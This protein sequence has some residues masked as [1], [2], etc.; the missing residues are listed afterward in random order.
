[1]HRPDARM[2]GIRLWLCGLA[3][4]L[5]LVAWALDLHGWM[6]S[7]PSDDIS[8]TLRVLRTGLCA[9]LPWIWLPHADAVDRRRLGLGLGLCALADGA[10][11]GLA[12]F[13]PGVLAFLVAQ[14]VLLRRAADGLRSAIA[15]RR[16]TAL[17]TLG[18]AGLIWLGLLALLGPPLAVRGFLPVV[19][20]YGLVLLATVAAAALGHRIGRHPG[21]TGRRMVW[22]MLCFALCDVLVGVGA[23]LPSEPLARLARLHTGWFYTPALLLLASSVR[24]SAD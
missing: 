21:P 12:A 22:G 6:R 20:V 7:T 4:A 10:L 9:A 8:R 23:A 13:V 16:A 2:K 1:M 17:R 18:L 24:P 14:L 5:T 11:V 3:I 15:T 19:A